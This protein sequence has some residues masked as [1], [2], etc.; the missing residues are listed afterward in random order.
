[1]VVTAVIPAASNFTLNA[2]LAIASRGWP[3]LPIYGVDTDGVCA[4]WRREA[5]LS[6]GKHPRLDNGVSG[7]SANEVTIR[8]W[9]ERQWPGRCNLGVATGRVSGLIVVDVDP[10]HDGFSTLARLERE[11]G[12]L[13]ADTPRVRTGSGGLHIYLQYPGNGLTIR[14]SA[15]ALGR[16]LDVR[17]DNGYVV[18]PPSVTDKGKYTW[19]A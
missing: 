19:L 9:F 13:P 1:V 14:N 12:P 4:C 16:G 11:L 15:G 3:V 2:A 17:G 8:R 18:V 7:A 5:C 10:K 6:P